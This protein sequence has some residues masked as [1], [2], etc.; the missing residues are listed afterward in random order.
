MGL[1][2]TFMLARAF[3]LEQTDPV[4]F[5]ALLGRDTVALVERY[6]D[7]SGTSVLEVG[8]GPG[9]I[10]VAF[11]EAGAR[12][13]FVEPS[14]EEMGERGRSRGWGVVADGYVLPMKD[15]TFDVCCCSNVLEHVGD[16][17]SFLDEMIRVTRPGGL[18]FVAFT[19]WLSPHGGHE[20]AP[21]HYL[22]GSWAARHYERKHGRPPKNL[23]GESL[24]NLRVG[25][26]MRWARRTPQVEILDYFPRYYPHWARGIVAMP[27]IRELATWNLALALQRR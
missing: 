3:R 27:G 1:R 23:F 16:P 17:W 4:A 6:R 22:G 15:A 5:Y 25:E 2:R 7:I 18:V 11:R 14:W 20:T 24:F 9:H 26:V 8:G 12:A 10:A 13:F 21:W 19:N